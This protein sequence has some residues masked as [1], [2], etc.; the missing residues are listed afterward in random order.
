MS[1]II[2]AP[3]HDEYDITS[4]PFAEVVE[5]EVVFRPN[6]TRESR[7]PL[8]ISRLGQLEVWNP[9]MV[10]PRATCCIPALRCHLEP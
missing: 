3:Q 6:A 10:I 5:G 9:A 7:Q 8:P 1:H 2:L 4:G